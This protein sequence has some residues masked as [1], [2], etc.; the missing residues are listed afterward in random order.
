MQVLVS[1]HIIED[2]SIILYEKRSSILFGDE[3]LSDVNRI[4]ALMLGHKFHGLLFSKIND[5]VKEHI[6]A[7]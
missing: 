4:R 3:Y 5:D 6:P 2:H 1:Y 7:L